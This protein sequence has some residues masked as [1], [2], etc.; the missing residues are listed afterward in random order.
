MT[1][2]YSHVSLEALTSKWKEFGIYIFECEFIDGSTG[3]LLLECSVYPSYFILGELG[4]SSDVVQ[5]IRAIP[6][7]W[8]S[9]TILIPLVCIWS[10]K[11]HFINL[12]VL[13]VWTPT[14]VDV[15]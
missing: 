10:T 13:V 8:T 5:V 9:Q 3:A 11:Y 2:Y 12:H 6:H 14:S 7:Y 15:S 1:H 4:G